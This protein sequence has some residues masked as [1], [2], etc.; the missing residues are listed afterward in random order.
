MPVPVQDPQEREAVPNSR[1]SDFFWKF[2]L[3]SSF[4]SAH[5]QPH[6][7]SKW[8]VLGP[9]TLPKLRG[10]GTTPRRT[11][12]DANPMTNWSHKLRRTNRCLPPKNIGSKN[13]PKIGFEGRKTIGNQGIS[14][15]YGILLKQSQ[16]LQGAVPQS[17][18]ISWPPPEGGRVDGR[19]TCARAQLRKERVGGTAIS[20]WSWTSWTSGQK[21]SKVNLAVFGIE[22]PLVIKDRNGKSTHL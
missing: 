4:L 7:K 13:P 6:P 10:F 8:R 21:M 5:H 9:P 14:R 3:R 22:H 19:P 11:L 15:L 12:H 1:R 16:L 2:Y 18:G 20:R 17:S